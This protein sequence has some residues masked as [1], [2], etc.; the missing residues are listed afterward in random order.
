MAHRRV[1]R[2]VAAV[3]MAAAIGMAL[4][5]S[6]TKKAHQGDG[7]VIGS[8]GASADASALSPPDAAPDSDSVAAAAGSWVESVRVGRWKE[9]ARML[10]ALDD[11]ERGQPEMRYVRARAAIA[12]SDWDTAARLLAGLEAALPTLAADIAFYRAEAQIFAGPVEEA[13]RYFAAQTSVESLVKAATAWEKAKRTQQARETIERAIRAAGKKVDDATIEAHAV[14]ARLAEAAGDKA[15]AASD[16]RFIAKHDP[17]R[18]DAEDIGDAIA[19]LDPKN[20]LTAPERMDRAHR[21][22]RE[23]NSQAAL[24]ELQRAAQSPGKRPSAGEMTYAKAMSLYLD[25]AHYSEAAEAFE[26]AARLDRAL[27]PEATWYAAKAWARADQN[28]R[29][30]ARYREIVRSFPKSRWGERSSY[31][32]ARLEMLQARWAEAAQSYGTYLAR[33]PRGGSLDSARYEQALC[34]L[35]SGRADRA[36]KMFDDIA[37]RSS[38]SLASGNARHLQAV[39]AWQAGD[40]PAAIAMWNSLV[41]ELP[42]TWHAM[43]ATSRLVSAGQAVPAAIQPPPSGVPEPLQIPLPAQAAMLRRLGLDHDAE[44]W[45]RDHEQEAAAAYG[46]R[47]GEVLCGMYGQLA[48]AHRRYKVGQRFAPGSWLAMSPS[49]ST[50]WS[51]DCVFPRPYPAFV[52]EL[53]RREGA[54]RGFLHS[55][56]RQESTFDPDARSPA[57]AIGLMQLLPVTARRI[58]EETSTPYDPEQLTSPAQNLDLAA[59]Y[60]GKLSR[61]FKGN[62]P[63]VAASYNAGPKAVGRWMDRAS[64]LPLDLWVAR[65]PYLETRHYVWK[66]MGNLARYGYAERAAEGLPVVDLKLPEGIEVGADAY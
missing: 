54:P 61:T 64:A 42:L 58:A 6:C 19:R 51:W 41:R 10:D 47:S 15:L 63:L 26:Q 8:V 46:S 22:A 30:S 66:V 38:D 59:R 49:A 33:Y 50:R 27:A 45:L 24:E 11:K 13:A 62:L 16:L 36:R 9:A 32:L 43:V 2:N 39:A 55:I 44:D 34:L 53:E 28:D 14:R 57:G 35:L 20:A 31:Q 29:A 3:W 17:S 4:S 23:G 25:R 1:G 56:M 60:V 21:L 7:Q 40:R 52:D 12:L 65:I 37:N 48:E 5:A 18:A